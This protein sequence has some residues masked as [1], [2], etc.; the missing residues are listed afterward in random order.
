MSE[1]EKLPPRIHGCPIHD[2]TYFHGDQSRHD[3]VKYPPCE[4]CGDV[5]AASDSELVAALKSDL[6]DAESEIRDL[7]ERLDAATA[8]L[9]QF[10]PKQIPL[11]AEGAW[12]EQADAVRDQGGNA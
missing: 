7:G 9:R 5:P 2:I 11:S 12:N 4:M 8:Q 1:C 3:G 6:A 10:N